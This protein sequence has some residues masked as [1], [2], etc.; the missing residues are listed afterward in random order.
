M[1]KSVKN[2]FLSL[3]LILGTIG[4][5]GNAH[6][7]NGVLKAINMQP[8]HECC[9]MSM[10]MKMKS[11]CCKNNKHHVK[12]ESHFDQVIDIVEV[13]TFSYQEMMKNLWESA[14]TFILPT[15]SLENEV[16]PIPSFCESKSPPNHR[17]VPINISYQVILV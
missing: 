6:I 11:D 7:C 15:T 8:S 10:D 5:V 1:L 17:T 4:I 16:H 9:A 3:I 12:V 2:I 13:P 14:Y